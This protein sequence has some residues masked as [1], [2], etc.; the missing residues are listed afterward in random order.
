GWRVFAD[1]IAGLF[2]FVSGISLVLSRQQWGRDPRQYRRRVLRRIA[3]LGLAAALVTLATWAVS[4]PDVVLFGILHLILVSSIAA[5]PLL[6]FGAWNLVLAIAVWALGSVVA[7]L[8][9]DPRLFWLGLVPDNYRSFDFRPFLP[10]FAFVLLGAAFASW[11]YAGRRPVD[12]LASWE[13][14]P[15]IR[16]L[17]TVGRHSLVLYLAHQPVLIALLGVLGLIDVHGLVG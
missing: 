1:F 4:P 3:R 12:R 11:F 14:H 15:V 8:P 10:W 5:Q 17:V 9:G 2:L 13:H 16:A 7:H 6:R